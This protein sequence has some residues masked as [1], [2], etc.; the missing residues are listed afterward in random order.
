MFRTS[1]TA[2]CFVPRMTGL[3]TRRARVLLLQGL[4]LLLGLIGSPRALLAQ[5]PA[6]RG[7]LSGVVLV[8]DSTA[9]P[10]PGATVRIDS[11]PRE[12][13]T[14]SAGRFFAR[15]VPAGERRLT[16]QAIGF[17]PV[18]FLVRVA[19]G[20]APALDVLLTRSVTNLARVET[21]ATGGLSR[22]WTR[23]FEE[24][25]KVGVGR[26]FDSTEF[27]GR[28]GQ[29]WVSALMRRVGGLKVREVVGGMRVLSGGRNEV[30]MKPGAQQACYVSIFVDDV[31]R[32]LGRPGDL[33]F[34]INSLDAA[35]IAAM[36]Y[37]STSQA[38][39]RYN[40]SGG[41]TCGVVVI[42]QKDR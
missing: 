31:P 42:W 14:D 30:S 15:E 23:E 24:R 41:A 35:N 27:A 18:T 4:A 3:R 38:P 6:G 40:V 1:T 13:R 34:D 8:D 19:P 20:S 28:D 22:L 36:E 25:R 39:T 11:D 21:R 26:F 2:E 9:R 29:A 17:E 10:I 32:Y 5:P 16:V 33:L 37:Y 12:L 7:S